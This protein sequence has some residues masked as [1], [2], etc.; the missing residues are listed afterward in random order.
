MKTDSL[1]DKDWSGVVARLGGAASLNTSA[2]ASKA[3]QRPRGIRDAVVLS[4]LILACCLGE[5]GPRATAAWTSPTCQIRP[6]C[7]G[8]AIV[9][10]G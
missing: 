1:L 5:R 2:R 8:Y 10:T 3:F 7:I 4:H 6:F 9:A